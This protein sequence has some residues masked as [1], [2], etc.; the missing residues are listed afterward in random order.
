[1][2]EDLFTIKYVASLV[3]SEPLA[4]SGSIKQSMAGRK[5]KTG[6]DAT[7]SGLKS[8][9]MFKVKQELMNREFR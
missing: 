4:L 6:P 9:D 5:R 2:L 8:W 1:M 3:E 7:R